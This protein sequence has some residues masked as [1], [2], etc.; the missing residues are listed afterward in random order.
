MH[1]ACLSNSKIYHITCHVSRI[2]HMSPLWGF[3]TFGLSVFY[4]HAAPLG[5]CWFI[6]LVNRMYIALRPDKS[7]FKTGVQGLAPLAHL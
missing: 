6:K 4:K 2:L 1:W 3:G 7:G 5:L